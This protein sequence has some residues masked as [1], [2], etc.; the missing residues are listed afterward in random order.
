AQGILSPRRLPFR[1]TRSRG[2]TSGRCAL[3]PVAPGG[4]LRPLGERRK[5][6]PDDLGIEVAAA[7]VD[8][9]A[10]IDPGHDALPAE[11]VGVAADA[12]GDQF[13]VLDIGI[14]W[15]DHARAEDLALG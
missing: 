1:H 8:R 6:G 7:G 10:A 4:D 5:L 9:E 14:L 12:L 15:L 2:R 11:Q 13:G 3:L